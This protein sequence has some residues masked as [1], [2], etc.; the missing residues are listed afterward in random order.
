MSTQTGE[1]IAFGQ[2]QLALEVS[3]H[4]NNLVFNKIMDS[5]SARGFLAPTISDSLTA[6]EELKALEAIPGRRLPMDELTRN[7]VSAP[8]VIQVGDLQPYGEGTKSRSIDLW[9]FVHGD[10]DSLKQMAE[11]QGAEFGN[12]L[13]EQAAAKAEEHQLESRAI[14]ETELTERG[15]EIA[16]HPDVREFYRNGEISLLDRVLLQITSRLTVTQSQRS[17]LIASELDN[18]FTGDDEFPNT[19]RTISSDRSK[20]M[21]PVA[22]YSGWQQYVKA[23]NLESL[24]GMILVEAHFWMSQP[25]D[26]FNGRDLLKSKIRIGSQTMVRKFRAELK[27]ASR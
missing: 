11:E 19:W 21:G 23:T 1:L 13:Q 9:F 20:T 5:T 3:K 16:P 25:N 27:R 6:D 10:W 22:P 15:I 8:F 14:G 7:A 24:P 18:R 17:I 12:L 2:E 4:E 26:W